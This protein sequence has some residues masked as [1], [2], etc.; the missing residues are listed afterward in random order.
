MKTK[1]AFPTLAKGQL[2]KMK[3]AY[4][5]IVD[6]GKRIIHFRMMERLGE[7]DVRIQMSPMHTLY[8]YLQARQARLV[9]TESPH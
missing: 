4:V 2:W 6:L 8:G 5:Q 3:H 1:R 9:R 7:A